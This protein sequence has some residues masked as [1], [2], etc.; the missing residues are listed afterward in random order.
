[1]VHW[2]ELSCGLTRRND[3]SSCRLSSFFRGDMS[4]DMIFE[5][6]LWA[7]VPDLHSG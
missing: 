7:Q 6:M 1:M 2:L 4:K 5:S 3:S